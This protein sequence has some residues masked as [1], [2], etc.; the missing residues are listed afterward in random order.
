MAIL[1][2]GGGREY[3]LKIV[4]DVQDA[5]KGVD[6]VQNKTSSMKDKM[7]GIGKGVA[8]GLAAGAVVEFGKSILNAAADADDANDVMQAAFGDT[9]KEFD[10]FAKSA[11]DNMGLSE[12]AYKNMAAKTGSLLQSVGISNQDAAKSTE[13]LS[14]RAADMAAIWGTDVPTASEAINKALVGSTKGLVQFGVKISAAEIDARAMGKG[15]VD[16]SGKVTDAGK[17]IAAQELILE[18]TSNV[19]GAYAANSKDLGSQ[20]DIMKAK[21]ENIQASLGA[22]LLPIITKLMTLF[23][24]ILDFIAKNINVL[25]PLAIGLGAVTAA[26]WLFNAAMAANPI[27]LV[28]AA[29]ALL[30][31]GIIIAYEKVGWFKDIVDAMWEGIQI[32][33][34]WVKENWP[35]LLA[36]LTGPIGIAVLMITKNWDTIKEAFKTAIGFITQVMGTV[37]DIL[38][39]PFRTAVAAVRTVLDT[40]PEIFRTLVSG[41]TRA[42]STIADVIA[43]PFK[44]GWDLAKSAGRVVTDWIGTISDGIRNTFSGIADVI[45]YPFTVAFNA[46]KTLWNSTVGGFSFSVPSW[47]PFVGG[48][49][50]KIPQMATGGIVNRPTIA[51]IGEQG[52]EAVVPLSMLG[53]MPN[54]DEGNTTIV[55]LNV[56]ALNASAQTGRQVYDSLREYAR[57]SGTQI[58]IG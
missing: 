11:A 17:A 47:V 3:V 38:T 48:K 14:Q 18:K 37:F 41:I 53:T 55:N 25:G 24:P 51:L 16:A 57:V 52:P 50:F 10:K 13:V 43:A 30:V 44:K 21:F 46:I 20:Q 8:A 23:Q 22:G 28:V 2:G 36:I 31:A 45:K 7:V 58:V 12:T 6:E 32:G 4:A 15:Y 39:L 26:V 1:G 19:Q 35:L 40:I 33:F 49:T 9:S 42:V 54:S 27:V 56:Y 29:I 34:K 5:V